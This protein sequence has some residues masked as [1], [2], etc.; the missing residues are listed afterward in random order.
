MENQNEPIPSGMT[1]EEIELLEQQRKAEAAA[2]IAPCMAAREQRQESADI[3]AEHDSVLA[4][5][6]YEMTIS[7]FGVEE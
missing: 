7:E 1:D 2:K 4:D 3:V 6:L 5:I